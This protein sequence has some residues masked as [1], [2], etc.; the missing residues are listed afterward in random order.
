LDGR[1]LDGKIE[2]PLTVVLLLA[3][4]RDA[5]DLTEGGVFFEEED[6]VECCFE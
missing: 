2:Y 3:E 1:R 4:S 5:V 6:E